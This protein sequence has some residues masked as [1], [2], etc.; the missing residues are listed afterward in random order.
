MMLRGL[1]RFGGYSEG[2]YYGLLWV[3]GKG[4]GMVLL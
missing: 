1:G 4:Y 3:V 2:E